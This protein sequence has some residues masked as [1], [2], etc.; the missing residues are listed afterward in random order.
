MIER[1]LK[2]P[3]R[4]FSQHACLKREPS[5]TETDSAERVVAVWILDASASVQ[6]YVKTPMHADVELD[7]LEHAMNCFE[8]NG[9][10]SP[11]PGFPQPP[12]PDEFGAIHGWSWIE[13]HKLPQWGQDSDDLAAIGQPATLCYP[14][15]V[16]PALN[17][18]V[19]GMREHVKMLRH[20]PG[21][22]GAFEWTHGID[23]DW[24]WTCCGKHENFAEVK[25][26]SPTGHHK[27]GC[28]TAPYC[29]E[30]FVCPCFSL[31]ASRKR[32]VDDMSK[33]F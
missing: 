8:E 15:L 24:R 16:T 31:I 5:C 27:T 7:P 11:A 18:R 33:N 21:G 32:Q 29:M 13:A 4:R 28:V 23:I 19:C 3:R 9:Q 20:H 26:C 6:V 10:P 1:L 12:A 25:S 22:C 17:C 14:V 30:C 2:K